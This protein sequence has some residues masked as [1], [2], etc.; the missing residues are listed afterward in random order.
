MVQ[1]E[2]FSREQA[3]ERFEIRIG[4]V[5]GPLSA[6]GDCEDPQ[7]AAARARQLLA[8]AGVSDITVRVENP[9]GP[10][11]VRGGYEFAPGAVILQTGGRR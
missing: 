2:T 9:G 4:D 6:Q 3:A 5:L 8:A 1:F 11:F 7:R 10:C